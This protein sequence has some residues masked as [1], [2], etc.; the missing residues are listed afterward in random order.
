MVK[1]A[2]YHY[3]DFV[4]AQVL[5]KNLNETINTKVSYNLIPTGEQPVENIVVLIGESVRKQNM[6]LY[7]YQ[8]ETTPNEVAERN[9]M[10]LYQNAYSPAAIT[11]MSVPI[12][13]SNIDIDNYQKE[14]KKL[15]DNIV[16]AASTDIETSD[17]S[18]GNRT[19]G[20]VSTKGLSTSV[21]RKGIVGTGNDHKNLAPFYVN[22]TAA[23]D[24]AA[25]NFTGDTHIAMYDGIL[26]TGN[27]Y[28][29]DFDGNG[30][31]RI[32]ALNENNPLSDYYKVSTDDGKDGWKAAKYRGMSNVKTY[33]SD[34]KLRGK[35][36][37]VNVGLINQVVDRSTGAPEEIEWDIKQA[38]GDGS[39]G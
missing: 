19:S 11:N 18:S 21:K 38:G 35:D 26:Y 37:G 36:G 17:F 6:S 14:L 32:W 30:N 8:R 28:D 34:N 1:N 7:G 27:G 15:S 39:Q 23:G 24:Q 4:A 12:V 10:L 22:R 9:N 29:P 3:S 5:K 16:N 25:I 2:I 33:I 31:S 20:K 13:L